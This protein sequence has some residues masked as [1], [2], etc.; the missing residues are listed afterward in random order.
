MVDYIFPWAASLDKSFSAVGVEFEGKIIVVSLFERFKSTERYSTFPDIAREPTARLPYALF[1]PTIVTHFPLFYKSHEDDNFELRVDALKRYVAKNAATH[2]KLDENPKNEI[3]ETILKNLEPGIDRPSQADLQHAVSFV[4]YAC[5]LGF[6]CAVHK[7]P[8]LFIFNA[9]TRIRLEINR[10]SHRAVINAIINKN[11]QP[12]WKEIFGEDAAPYKPDERADYQPNFDIWRSNPNLS[13]QAFL[14]TNYTEF[15]FINKLIGASTLSAAAPAQKTLPF[16]EPYRKPFLQ[17]FDEENPI[18]LQTT[19]QFDPQKHLGGLISWFDATSH[20]EADVADVALTSRKLFPLGP[21]KWRDTNNKIDPLYDEYL[22]WRR[23]DRNW[24]YT[25]FDGC[26]EYPDGGA[27]KLKRFLSKLVQSCELERSFPE[28]KLNSGWEAAFEKY[29]FPGSRIAGAMYY[30][31]PAELLIVV[32]L[33]I[34]ALSDRFSRGAD[35]ENPIRTNVEHRATSRRNLA[36]CLRVLDELEALMCGATPPFPLPPGKARL[37]TTQKPFSAC[38]NSNHS[39]D[40]Q[41]L[42]SARAIGQRVA[43]LY[44]WISYGLTLEEGRAKETQERFYRCFVDIAEIFWKYVY[45]SGTHILGQDDF[46]SSSVIDGRAIYFSNFR[47]FETDQ[48]LGFTRTLFVDFRLTPYQRGR[49]VRRLCDI[50]T[51]RMSCVKDIDRLHALSDGISQINEDFNLLVSVDLEDLTNETKI[52]IALH[53]AVRLYQRALGFNMFI[54][55]G[56]AGRKSAAHGD[57]LVVQKQIADI[58]EHRLPGHA[59]LQDFLERGLGQSILEIQQIA[60]RYENLMHRISSHMSTIRT[61]LA[62]AHTK[63]NTVILEKFGNLFEDQ[64]ELLEDQRN[65]LNRQVELLSAAD[66]LV[67]LGGT[68][69]LW[70]MIKDIVNVALDRAGEYYGIEH[71]SD[72][73]VSEIG[74]LAVSL[75]VVFVLV[76]WFKQQLRDFAKWIE[77][78]TR[79]LFSGKVKKGDKPTPK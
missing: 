5:Q 79:M 73:V 32:L 39:D 1:G 11:P 13:A 27:D 48:T 78:R 18:K 15:R 22:I 28:L 76:Y 40:S 56:V 35:R 30:V 8:E 43:D 49:L 65:F 20:A 77:K 74:L 75:G 51:F 37:T 66:L 33:D 70:R 19:P 6:L 36:E 14:V 21:L 54:T 61:W 12:H 58:R 67:W 42:A 17:Q 45:G 7:L 24:R 68:Y 62:G 23:G 53:D 9:N 34:T 52:S 26:Y 69:Y 50:A 64:K 16:L 55:E 63:N 3:V 4:W 47:P 44:D 59:Q 41:I 57:W 2:L 72:W 31:I 71:L 25:F 38:A 60:D 46:V 29:P 10:Y